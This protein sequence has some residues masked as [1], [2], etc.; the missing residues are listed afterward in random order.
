MRAVLGRVWCTS[1]FCLVPR[2]RPFSWSVCA[3]A[4]HSETR[5]CAGRGGESSRQARVRESGRAGEAAA[6]VMN[7]V[8]RSGGARTDGEALAAEG[9]ALAAEGLLEEALYKYDAALRA[10]ESLYRANPSHPHIAMRYCSIG[11]LYR[12]DGDDDSALEYFAKAARVEEASEG[13]GR[14]T[15]LASY[16]SNLGGVFRSKGDV[17]GANDAYCR[18]LDHLRKAMP[19]LNEIERVVAAEESE[20]F[21]READAFDRDA[22][23]APGTGA[24]HARPTTS[25]D[26]TESMLGPSGFLNTAASVLNNLGLLYKSLGEPKS[27]RRCYL[28]AIS[29]AVIAVGE[30]DPANAARHRN[31]G[32]ALLDMGH[33]DLALERFERAA[34]MCALGYGHDHPETT[35]ADEWVAFAKAKKENQNAGGRARK[36]DAAAD[37]TRGNRLPHVLPS[38][39]EWFL[40]ELRCGVL[41]PAPDPGLPE[42]EEALRREEKENAAALKRKFVGATPEGDDGTVTPI[43]MPESVA[44]GGMRG[45]VETGDTPAAMETPSGE[46][47]S[48]EKVG[49]AAIALAKGAARR[50]RLFVPLEPERGEDMLAPYAR[51]RVKVV[52]G[53]DSSPMWKAVSEERSAVASGAG[54]M[55]A[56]R[57]YI[58]AYLEQAP[59]YANLIT[60]FAE[61]PTEL[62]MPYSAYKGYG[63][64]RPAEPGSLPRLA[65]RPRAMEKFGS[66][67]IRGGRAAE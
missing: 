10:D 26:D 7:S 64:P 41:E 2:V 46:A 24:G 25:V 31:L 4:R 42:E 29:L 1:G 38:V 35:R 57:D 32:A 52:G 8:S 44:V 39:V 55:P 61:M 47:R 40:E 22:R 56:G 54:A 5:E 21:E 62:L 53:D 19:P 59:G 37:E 15:A 27:A 9:D 66:P 17:D 63:V 14:R 43:P 6:P 67:G 34:G 3:R 65:H 36:E 12:A 50:A 45:L 51:P 16:L 30:F 49:V 48:S 20:A 13:S 58:A 33:T 23:D 60:P 11:A 28:R 18:A